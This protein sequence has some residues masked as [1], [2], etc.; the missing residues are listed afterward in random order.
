VAVIHDK[1]Q[2]GEGIASSVKAALDKAGVKVVALRASPPA[3]RTSP[4]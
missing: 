4:P 1:K 2:Y 3:T